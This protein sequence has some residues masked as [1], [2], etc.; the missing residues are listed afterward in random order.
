MEAIEREHYGSPSP[1]FPSKQPAGHLG[2]KVPAGIS[3][4]KAISNDGIFSAGPG[5]F[6]VRA[7]LP[8]HLDSGHMM[9]I[10]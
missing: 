6:A 7:P 2:F 3:G 5:V 8:A 9:P 4:V 10:I 1:V